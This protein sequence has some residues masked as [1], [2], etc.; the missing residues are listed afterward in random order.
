MH[1]P[2]GFVTAAP[3]MA[4]GGGEAY[5]HIPQAGFLLPGPI[6]SLIFMLFKGVTE[7]FGGRTKPYIDRV[8]SNT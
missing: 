2:R 7:L 3:S 6:A 5:Q 4:G 1:G 8:T